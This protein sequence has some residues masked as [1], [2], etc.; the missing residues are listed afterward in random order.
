L[1]VIVTATNS[2]G[3]T[4][5]ISAPTALVTSRPVPPAERLLGVSLP[6][7][8]SWLSDL[9]AYSSRVGRV[10]SVVSTYRDMETPLLATNMMDAVAARGS[11]PLV[12]VEPWDSASA[13]DPRYALRNIMR[14][15]FDTWFAAGA[16]AARNYGR[17]FYLRFAPEMNGV[18]APWGAGINGNT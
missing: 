8:S 6:W 15:D 5:A 3:S 12:T 10:P 17:P 14:G 1:R 11:I 7:S 18:W 2:A 13:T 4:S 9:D 16:D